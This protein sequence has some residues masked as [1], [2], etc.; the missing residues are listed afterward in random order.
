[1]SSTGAASDATP[2]SSDPPR[3][4]LLAA[5]VAV[6]L[7]GV[8]GG[9]A[10]EGIVDLWPGGTIPWAV[11]TINA[12][13]AFVLGVVVEVVTARS[14]HR[15]PIL[16][17][18]VSR[19]LLGTGFCG[20][21]TTFS[22]LAVALDTLARDDRPAAAGVYLGLSLLLGLLAVVAGSGVGRRVGR[23]VGR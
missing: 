17:A 1:M 22:S 21:F 13:G 11:L 2:A 3:T 8:L 4:S 16:A 7:G 20:G 14:L 15:H 18:R 12:A 5:A 23:R 6:F 9:L 10:R 19:P